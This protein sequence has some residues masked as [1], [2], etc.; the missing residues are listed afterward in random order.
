MVV[1]VV[2]CVLF[3]ENLF[4]FINSHLSLRSLFKIYHIFNLFLSVY[5]TVSKRSGSSRDGREEETEDL[6]KEIRFFSHLQLIPPAFPNTSLIPT[7][8][9]T[10]SSSSLSLLFLFPPH[11]LLT[12]LQVHHVI[13]SPSPPLR[14]PPPSPSPSSRLFYVPAF[15]SLLTTIAG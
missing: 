6:F 11:H 1:S 12:P 10:P 2:P 14:S 13:S 4:S 15:R 3:S 9:F 5:T 8:P 7:C